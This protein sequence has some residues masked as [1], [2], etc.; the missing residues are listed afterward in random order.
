MRI[1]KAQSKYAAIGGESFW[2]YN[3]EYP[4]EERWG[5]RAWYG[6]RFGFAETSGP[7]RGSTG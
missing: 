7:K 3:P 6:N 1:T 4:D 5:V 2:L